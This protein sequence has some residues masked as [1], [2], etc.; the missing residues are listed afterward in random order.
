MPPVRARSELLETRRL[1]TIEAVSSGVAVDSDSELVLQSVSTASQIGTAPVVVYADRDT[2][3]GKGKDIFLRRF[4]AAGAALSAPVMVNTT[5]SGAQ[6]NPDV[7]INASGTFVVVWQSENQ[8]GDGW[9]VYARRYNSAGVAQGGE[10][11]V[12]TMTAGAQTAPKVAI[13]SSGNFV[14]TYLNEASADGVIMARRFQADG[15]PIAEITVS[16][17]GSKAYTSPVIAM[18]GDGSFAVAFVRTNLDTDNSTDIQIQAYASGGAASGSTQTIA[19]PGDQA[20][21]TLAAGTNFVLAWADASTSEATIFFRSL[22]PN[23]AWSGAAVQANQDSLGN[24]T[25]PRVSLDTNNN[26]VLGWTQQEQDTFYSSTVYRSFNS[27]SAA[28]SNETAVTDGSSMRTLMDVSFTAQGGFVEISTIGEFGGYGL[29]SITSMEN[30]IRF[31]GSDAVDQVVAYDLNST[32]VRSSFN[33]VVQN[34][35]KSAFSRIVAD[36]K[37]ANDSVFAADASIMFTVSGGDGNDTIFT[38]SANDSI[39][40]GNG[41][42]SINA[43]GGSDYVIGNSDNDIVYGGSGDDTLT[44]S[45][46]KDIMYG[47]DGNDR[48]AGTGSPDRIFGEGGDDRLYGDDGDDRLDGG[49]GKDRLYGGEGNDYMEGGS[50]NDRLYGQ[51]GNDTLGGGKGNDYMVGDSGIDT[52]LG[53]E[54][55]DT[56]LDIEVM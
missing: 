48:V 49:G 35:E 7:A 56:V 40:G 2:S 16:S 15:T 13:D 45:A 3:T 39:G 44:G 5:T 34:Y 53:K 52:V 32:T 47:G 12:N 19:D 29:G 18:R 11:L 25:Q 30:V 14:V 4:S 9:G 55:G 46:G 1:L 31:D 27:A 21:P 54:P 41:A 26:V 33:G 20:S 42:D 28:M 51:A 8:D 50:S 38:G 43:G 10:T 24:R 17:G 37:G 22:A 6:M 36:L 23:G